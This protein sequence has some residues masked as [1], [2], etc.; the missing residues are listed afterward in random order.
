[1][2]VLLLNKESRIYSSNAYLVL[3][4]WNRLDDMNTLIDV[5]TDESILREIRKANTGVGKKR[6]EQVILTHNHFDHTGNL[7]AI[8]ETYQPRVYAYSDG[9]YVDE[10]LK[11]GQKLKV[12]DREFEVIHTPVHSSDSI[13][14][15]C[16]E[17]GILFSGDTPLRIIG[18]GGTYSTSFV[19]VLESL[20][21]LDI[22]AVYSGHDK[23]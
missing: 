23:P 7:R 3:G 9:E 2:K 5:G 12:G 14:L 16:A 22:R 8:T 1:M 13:C 18:I 4:T 10:T 6:V 17:E 19:T 21:K 11:D 15:Y 20:K